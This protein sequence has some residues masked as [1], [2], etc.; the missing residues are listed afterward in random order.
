MFLGTECQVLRILSGPFDLL[1]S[2]DSRFCPYVKS[3]G[4]WVDATWHAWCS[5]FFLC[6]D[7]V[8]LC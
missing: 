3:G 2:R 5:R 6:E 8:Q 7:G 1:V 4:G